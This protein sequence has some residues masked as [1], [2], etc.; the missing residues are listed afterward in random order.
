M[1]DFYC[2][3]AC[4]ISNHVLKLNSDFRAHPIAEM[5]ANN[6]PLVIS[7][8]DPSFWETFTLTHDFYILFVY[9]CSNLHDMRVV[10]KLITNSMKYSG[11]TKEELESLFPNWFESWVDWLEKVKNTNVDDE[12]KKLDILSMYFVRKFH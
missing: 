11:L 7:S 6:L 9:I 4:P 5:L 12:K 8:D 3:A 10:K 1:N 2:F